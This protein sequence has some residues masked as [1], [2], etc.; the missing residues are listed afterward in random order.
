VEWEV[1]VEARESEGY[2]GVAEIGVGNFA[3][4]WYNSLGEL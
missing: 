1:A 4:L 2:G 3:L